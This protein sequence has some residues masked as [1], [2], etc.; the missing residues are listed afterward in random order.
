MW[1]ATSSCAPA[2]AHSWVE[3]FFPTYGWLTFDPTPAAEEVAPGS[4]RAIRAL[5]GLVSTAVERVIINYD[6]THQITL[7]QNL[8]RVSR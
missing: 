4:F 8:Q 2:D 6:F 1:A 5:L 7:A 3:V